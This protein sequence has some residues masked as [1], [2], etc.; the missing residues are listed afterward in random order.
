MTQANDRQAAAQ[1][2]CSVSP[3]FPAWLAQSGGSL[4]LSTYQAGKVATIGWDGRQVA[5][6]MRQFDKP[7]GLAVEGRRLA[8][9]TRHSIEVFADAALLARE[10]LEGRPG[11]YDA[12]YLPRV[13]YHTGD[14]NAHDV[15]FEDGGLVFVNTRFSCLARVSYDHHFVPVWRPSFVSDLVPEDRCHLNGLA[16]VAGRPKYVT[17]LGATDTPGGWREN[18]ASGGVLIDVETGQVVVD[19]LSMPHSP[20]WHEGRLWVLNSGTGELLAVDPETG[21]YEVVCGLPGYVRGLCL[22]GPFA[23]VG[24][25]KIREKHIFGG[26]PIQQRLERLTCGVA[27][28]DLRGGSLLGLFEFTSGCEELYDVQFL[29]G[30]RRPTILNLDKPAVYEAVTNPDSSYWLRAS[31]QRPVDGPPTPSTPLA[32]GTGGG[33]ESNQMDTDQNGAPR[34]PSAIQEAGLPPERE[35]LLDSG[36]QF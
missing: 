15:A 12:L 31:Q 17:A 19:S 4:V 16:M 29:P 3:D 20:R 21:R 1:I 22:A 24:M 23:L 2:C 14:L 36:T 26:L 5:L 18:K 30:V 8:L 25:C 34:L 27:V 32:A 11:L 35:S 7:L 33:G 28:V 6:L 10:Y 13:S 9:A